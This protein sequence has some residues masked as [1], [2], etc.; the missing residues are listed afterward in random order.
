MT[1]QITLG[2]VSDKSGL[3]RFFLI[4]G[5]KKTRLLDF[6]GL[7]NL[8]ID[9]IELDPVVWAKVAQLS[10]ANAALALHLFASD[11]RK[12]PGGVR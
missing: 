3:F 9:N 5:D 12:L 4:E 8:M 11:Q 6:G 10:G 1:P 7:P 2:R